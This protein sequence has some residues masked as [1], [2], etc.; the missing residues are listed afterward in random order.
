VTLPKDTS[1]A[2]AQALDSSGRVLAT[3]RTVEV[4]STA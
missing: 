1:F 2:A 4:K 3:S